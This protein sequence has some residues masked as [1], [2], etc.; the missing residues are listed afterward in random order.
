MDKVLEEWADDMKKN[1]P[2][3]L[4]RL[5]EY[6]KDHTAYVRE[7]LMEMHRLKRDEANPHPEDSDEFTVYLKSCAEGVK[8]SAEVHLC[9]MEQ[10]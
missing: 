10:Q 3:E 2:E 4:E 1:N 6:Q 5:Q 7:K 8:K 9:A